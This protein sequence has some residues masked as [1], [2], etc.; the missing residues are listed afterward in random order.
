GGLRTLAFG[1]HLVLKTGSGR[2]DASLALVGREERFTFLLVLGGGGLLLG[3]VLGLQALG[4]GL[5]H[6]AC[7]FLREQR[8]AALQRGF[9]G[10][11]QD[12]KVDF[13]LDLLQRA[14]DLHADHV[15]GLVAIGLELVFGEGR[16]GNA[17]GGERSGG[18]Q[19]VTQGRF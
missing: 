7:L 14:A 8:R 1:D 3:S 12:R 4:E 13:V 9:D 17:E 6:R 16:A 18:K 15:A 19:R 2:L 5:L 10:L 11:E